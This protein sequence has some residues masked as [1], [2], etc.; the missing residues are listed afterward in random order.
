M[1]GFVLLETTTGTP[2]HYAMWKDGFGVEGMQSHGDPRIMAIG[3]AA[4]LSGMRTKEQFAFG[5][6][7]A[8]DQLE[9]CGGGVR[10]V[11]KSFPSSNMMSVVSTNEGVP[12]DISMSLAKAIGEKFLE[13][14]SEAS[15]SA[16]KGVV[17]S[18]KK[19][20]K[21]ITTA[22]IWNT[23]QTMSNSLLAMT[24]AIAKTPWMVNFYSP[25]MAL[26]AKKPPNV[27]FT[28]QDAA[29]I[30]QGLEASSIVS[31]TEGAKTLEYPLPWMKPCEEVHNFLPKVLQSVLTSL[32]LNSS[33]F[34]LEPSTAAIKVS[35]DMALII[36]SLGDFYSVM[37]TTS[38]LF[39]STL[40][41]HLL[42]AEGDG[43]RQMLRFTFQNNITP[44]I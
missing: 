44:E 33:S 23:I 18:Y 8:G 32:R 31:Q 27:S 39:D 21:P 5:D 35:N 17:K 25:D 40:L 10:L 7:I 28:N 9:V 22:I 1:N 14:H 24:D 42:E 3:I 2:I 6:E 15:E 41:R 20:M 34:S 43:L 19:T 30:M 38:D 11:Q 26:A 13:K 36:F 12:R 16:A 29:D 37:P 4:L